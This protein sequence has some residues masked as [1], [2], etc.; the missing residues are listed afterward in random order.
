MDSNLDL[1]DLAFLISGVKN[2]LL[3]LEEQVIILGGACLFSRS[4]STVVN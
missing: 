4:V 2:G 1:S 3:G